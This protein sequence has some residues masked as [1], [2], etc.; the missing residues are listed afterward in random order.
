[1]KC[2]GGKDMAFVLI[3]DIKILKLMDAASVHH[4]LEPGFWEKFCHPTPTLTSNL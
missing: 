4:L 1:M 3:E 2:K